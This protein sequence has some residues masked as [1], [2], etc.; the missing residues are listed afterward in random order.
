MVDVQCLVLTEQDKDIL[1]HPLV[2]GLI[3]FARN[4]ENAQQVAEL[5]KSIREVRAD[6]FLI[7]VD[8]EGGRVQ[9]FREE[10]SSLPPLK[11]L[12]D[13]YSKNSELAGLFAFQH[14]W[15][16]AT[17]VQSVGVDFSF[18]PVLDI[19]C[20]ISDVIGDRSFGGDPDVVSELGKHYISG[21]RQAG[22]A[23]TGKHFPGHGAIKEDSHIACPVDDRSLDQLLNNDI[24]PFSDTMRD[25]LDAVMPSHVI[26]PEID[27]RPAGF[28]TVWIQDIL[29]ARLGFDGVVF[30]DDL[31][32]EGA[33]F[34][35]AYADRAKAALRAGC[36]MVLACN[37][38]SGVENILDNLAVAENTVS[39]N[40]LQRMKAKNLYQRE[41]MQEN[42]HWREAVKT[43]Q[44]LT[45]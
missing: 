40:R 27:E 35:G 5:T 13:L 21:M 30:S 12:G 23:A 39:Q 29:R 31:G 28:S 18:A 24:K 8:Q 37:N 43:I 26:Y 20:G 36:D 42:V 41:V 2:G 17:E 16:M 9:R 14:G 7:A 33:S 3:L 19:D 34:A 4:Y 6:D 10:F 22:M 32:M 25:G 45:G 44:Q 1:R 38:R 11:T 15:L